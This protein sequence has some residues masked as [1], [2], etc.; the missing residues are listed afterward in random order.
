MF[1]YCHKSLSNWSDRWEGL[2][3]GEI[4]SAFGV[5]VEDLVDFSFQLRREFL[6]QVKRSEAI[7]KLFDI[8]GADDAGGSVFEIQCPN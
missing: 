4:D 3:G 6:Q 2:S 8:A 5:V 7:L 1:R